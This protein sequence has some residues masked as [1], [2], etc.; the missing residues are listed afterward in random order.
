MPR[1]GYRT[2][3]VGVSSVTT[4]A[5]E[6]RPATVTAAA[7]LLFLQA[8]L[9]GM[10]GVV[11]LLALIVLGLLA[12]A[13]GTW[14]IEAAGLAATLVIYAIGLPAS[15]L[16]IGLGLWSLRGWAW[17]AGLLLAGVQILL[18][19]VVP[20]SAA[21]SSNRPG[22]DL[23]GAPLAIVP[24]IVG[25]LLLTKTARL[26]FRGVAANQPGSA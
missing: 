13:A 6:A 14:N 3:F 17:K 18:L 11:A 10:V 19:V 23:L 25:A 16:V 21:S 1:E 5:L 22:I 8:A 12:S 9:L 4:N 24:I 7:L 20:L 2:F 15:S 26:A